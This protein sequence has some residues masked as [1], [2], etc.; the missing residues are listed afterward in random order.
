[1]ATSYVVPQ[2]RVFQQFTATAPVGLA[3]MTACMV[4]PNYK[5]FDAADDN[6]IVGRYFGEAATFNY[7]WLSGLDAVLGE[8]T[9]TFKATLKDAAIELDSLGATKG[10]VNAVTPGTAYFSDANN[11]IVTGG[12]VAQG[13]GPTIVGIPL[14]KVNDLVIIGSDTYTITGFLSADTKADQVG[15]PV[16][17]SAT[18]TDV[19]VTATLL[20][21]TDDVNKGINTYTIYITQGFTGGASVTTTF[22]AVDASGRTV[23]TVVLSEEPTSDVSFTK[24]GVKLAFEASS[25]WGS[26]NSIAITT[27]EAGTSGYTTIVVDRILSDPSTNPAIVA[28]KRDIVLSDGEGVTFSD[29][30]VTLDANIKV[31][32]KA[33]LSGE[34]RLSFRALR[35]DTAQDIRTVRTLTDAEAILGKADIRNP[36]A[37]M[38][39]KAIQNAN[40]EAVAFLA[41]NGTGEAAYDD[42]FAKLDDDLVTY[43]IVPYSS[44]AQIGALLKDKINELAGATRMNWKIGW[45]SYAPAS[46]LVVVDSLNVV[47]GSSSSSLVFDEAALSEVR[48]GDRVE[49]VKGDTSVITSTVSTVSPQTNTIICADVI[50]A[51]TYSVSVIHIYSADEKADLIAEYAA[52]MDDRRI[53]LVTSS[54]MAL[55]ENPDAEY[56][57]AYVAAAVAG[58]RSASAPHQPLTRVELVGFVPTSGGYTAAAMDKMAGNGTWIV[59][60]DVA[61]NVFT[62]HQ[63]TTCTSDYKLRED[64]KTTNADEISKYYREQLSEYYGR[65]NVSDE[66]IELL[67]LKLDTIHQNIRSRPWK[68]L[69]GPQIISVLETEILRDPDLSDRL[70][71][72]D[73]LSTPDPLN[74]LDVYLTIA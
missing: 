35:R 55:T 26:G 34:V 24:L 68:A 41:T 56:S 52:T 6:A 11:L 1:M 29:T 14:L 17:T 47:V 10:D 59:T 7:P 65:A 74:N 5:V 18:A 73:S 51:N 39:K 2:L 37:L 50:P 25:E 63:L 69:I 8:D 19:D 20:G 64:S 38:V 49:L 66:F 15:K 28:E 71:V 4:G 30:D 45:L 31:G 23:E 60:S 54:G 57:D 32:G 3:S 72:K 46:E 40:G 36:L 61:G 43:S 16:V 42:A 53:R 58:L 12:I 67:Y 48:P 70:I 27:I 22:Q 62:R 13:R 33:V 44:D 9:G 21:G